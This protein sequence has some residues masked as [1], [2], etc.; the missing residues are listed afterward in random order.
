MP[1]P[2]LQISLSSVF[3]ASLKLLISFHFSPNSSAA[4]EPPALQWSHFSKQ[5]EHFWGPWVIRRRS[6]LWVMPL[7]KGVIGKVEEWD[8]GWGRNTTCH[9]NELNLL[10]VQ[11]DLPPFPL[12][13][14]C[15][16]LIGGCTCWLMNR[17]E[18]WGNCLL[19]KIVENLAEYLSKNLI[20]RTNEIHFHFI[21]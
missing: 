17:A 6:Q 18:V 21:C 9:L 7:G 11:H 5:L 8:E 19:E 13:H 10:H 2:K 4:A 16:A 1:S 20:I 14:T 12:S 15:T 3:Q